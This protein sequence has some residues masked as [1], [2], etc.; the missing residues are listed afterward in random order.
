MRKLWFS[1]KV[2]DF[3]KNL[4]EKPETLLIY[5]ITPIAYKLWINFLNQAAWQDYTTLLPA[6]S[7]SI[8][9]LIAILFILFIKVVRDYINNNPNLFNTI[10]VV[11]TIIVSLSFYYVDN[12]NTLHKTNGLL[13]VTDEINYSTTSNFINDNDYSSE[14]WLNFIIYP[15]EQNISFIVKNHTHACAQDYLDLMQMTRA[16]NDLNSDTNQKLNW[17]IP[18]DSLPTVKSMYVLRKITLNHMASST[19]KLI[20]SILLNCHGINI[21]SKNGV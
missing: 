15:Y 6:T 2:S 12:L 13:I 10:L 18:N 17:V 9:A 5:I 19:N 14:Q 4:H 21:E 20:S 16:F 11:F 3:V 7:K 8:G 1:E